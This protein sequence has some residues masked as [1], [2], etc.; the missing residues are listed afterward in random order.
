MK[1]LELIRLLKKIKINDIININDLSIR[2]I[3]EYN[4]NIDYFNVS[5]DDID[6]FYKIAFSKIYW[7][8]YITEK[9][10]NKRIKLYIILF[11]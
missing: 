9:F 3:N 10:Y 6:Y 7:Y 1:K 4:L 2:S 5:N 8:L 11:N